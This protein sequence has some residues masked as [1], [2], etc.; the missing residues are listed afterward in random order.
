MCRLVRWRIQLFQKLCFTRDFCSKCFLDVNRGICAL[1][2]ICSFI[3]WSGATVWSMTQEKIC[4]PCACTKCKPCCAWHIARP[5]L[6]F[7][8]NFGFAHLLFIRIK[9][10]KEE[11]LHETK[12]WP[13]KACPEMRADRK[14]ENGCSN[15]C[16]H[17]TMKDTKKTCG[18]CALQTVDKKL[19]SPRR[20]RIALSANE[21]I[22]EFLDFAI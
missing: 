21:R 18:F 15:A 19:F 20:G 14:K 12:D 9:T 4:K 22:A 6:E 13:P 10:E 3:A 16:P 11:K 1:F 2:G 7:V 8:Q 5:L 17:D